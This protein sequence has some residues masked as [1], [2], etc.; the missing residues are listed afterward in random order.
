MGDKSFNIENCITDVILDMPFEF[1]I[2]GR[3]FCL[4]PV[5]LAK[6]LVLKRK[7]EKLSLDA[8]TLKKNPY[9]EAIRVAHERKPDCCEILA[10]HA[11]KNTKAD[12]HDTAGINNIKEFFEENMSEEDI[13]TFLVAVLT[14]DNT[15]RLTRHLGLDKERERLSR[16]SAIKGRHGKNNL[17]FGGKSLFGAFIGQL[18]EKGYT[19]DQICYEK[20]Y[21]YLSLIL[22]DW[23]TSIYISDE[24]LSDMPTDMGGTMLDGNDPASKAALKE[25]LRQRGVAGD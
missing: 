21:T 7:I 16:V 25:L 24:E 17:T 6:K 22:A 3:G 10:L 14:N 18:K 2:G 11:T 12:F 8:E 19:D 13:A 20:S 23:I 5:T 9:L 15:E 4:Y 1:S